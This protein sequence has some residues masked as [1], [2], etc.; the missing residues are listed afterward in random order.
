MISPPWRSALT[1]TNAAGS[2][3][4]AR[5]AG[6]GSVDRVEPKLIWNAETPGLRARISGSREVAKS[7]PARA[8][9]KLPSGQL[10]AVAAVARKADDYGVERRMPRSPESE[11]GGVRHPRLQI[12]GFVLRPL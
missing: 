9:D 6:R 3:Q 7:L 11:H 4:S 8:V 2:S 1:F 12:N 5:R 10:S